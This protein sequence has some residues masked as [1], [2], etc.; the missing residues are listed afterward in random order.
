MRWLRPREGEGVALCVHGRARARP[1]FL[2]SR[3]GAISF[4]SCTTC[5]FPVVG[6]TAS[7]DLVALD[8][9]GHYRDSRGWSGISRASCIPSVSHPS[10]LLAVPAVL[11]MLDWPRDKEMMI[12]LTNPQRHWESSRGWWQAIRWKVM[13]VISFG[14]PESW[15]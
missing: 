8:Q 5:G 15:S 12:P 14:R 2:A 13:G 11:W 3:S 7:P 10:S 4:S 1:G 9:R 6:C